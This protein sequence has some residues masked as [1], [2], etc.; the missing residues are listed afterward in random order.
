VLRSDRNL[1]FAG[2][3]NLGIRY[4]L[5]RGA[6]Y[7]WLLN[8]DTEVDG[9][10]LSALVSAAQSD[11]TVGMWG[12]KVYYFNRPNVIWY[13]GGEIW[14]SDYNAHHIGFNEVDTGAYDG[15]RPT[16][17]VTGCSLLVPASVVERIGLMSEDYF[18]YWKRSTGASERTKRAWVARSSRRWSSG[19]RQCLDGGNDRLRIR[20]ETRND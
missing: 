4:A 12:S 14:D 20:Y 5:D 2:G 6:T 18:L 7:V 11:P 9:H 1:G 3:N 8:N 15:I 19:T 13:V 17:Y 16:Q 10:A